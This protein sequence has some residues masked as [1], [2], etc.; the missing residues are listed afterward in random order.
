M[1]KGHTYEKWQELGYQVNK[2]QKSTYLFY[3]NNIFTRDQVVNTYNDDDEYL[4]S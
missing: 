1:A 2:G 4:I 3:G